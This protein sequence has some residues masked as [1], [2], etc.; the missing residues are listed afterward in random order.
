MNAPFLQVRYGV[1]MAL[2]STIAETEAVIAHALG[3]N[4]Q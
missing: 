4:S 2:I 3:N 1:P